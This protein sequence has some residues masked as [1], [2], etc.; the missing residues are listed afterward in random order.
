MTPP[1]L[2]PAQERQARTFIQ[3]NLPLREVPG[4]GLR[5][6]L[7]APGSG[8]R[9]LVPPG[10][11]PYW[12]HVWPGGLALAQHIAQGNLAGPLEDARPETWDVG[13]GS[14]LAGLAAARAGLSVV[15]LDSDPLA[16]VALQ[17]NAEANGLTI[18]TRL[19][20]F[21]TTP[22]VPDG[23]PALLLAGDVFY[24]AKVAA[25]ATACFDAQP[26]SVTVL[27]GDI[28]RSY[29]PRH[30]LERLSRHAVRDVGDPPSMPSHDGWVYRWAR[31]PTRKGAPRGALPDEPA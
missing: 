21:P 24:D 14:G 6:H 1:P 20:G 4:T 25:R 23:R 19:A 17:L 13:A 15:A 9:R 18:Q 12:A 16:L 7:A 5:L 31:L 3:A 10:R 8:L 22:V 27:V 11:S 26:G 29:L 28:G 30:R 2:S